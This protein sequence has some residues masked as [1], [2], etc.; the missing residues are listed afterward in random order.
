MKILAFDTTNLK[1]SIAL[2]EG[3]NIIDLQIIEESQKQAEL[4]I[5]KIEEILTNNNISYQDLDAIGFSKGPASFTTLR[6]GLCVA[7]T[8]SLVLKIPFYGFDSLFL[9]ASKFKDFQGNIL[10]I[11]DAKMDEFFIAEFSCSQNKLTTI[12]DS[13]LITLSDL[14]KIEISKQHLICS[15]A[16]YITQEI[17]AKRNIACSIS[18]NNDEISADILAILAQEKLKINAKSDEDFDPSYLRNP[19]IG[20]RKT[21]AK[22]TK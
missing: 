5:I 10:V 2:L 13:R 21:K 17:L 14:K 7:K 16:K 6:I 11:S 1:P 19:K 4:L 18:N 12:Q 3:D 20:V 8:L 9:I 22:K 15:S